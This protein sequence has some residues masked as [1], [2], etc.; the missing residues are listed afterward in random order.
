MI[1]MVDYTKVTK[2]GYEVKRIYQ[3][4]Q[5]ANF[6]PFLIAVICR[7][8]KYYPYMWAWDY[9]PRNGTWGQGNY[10][11]ESLTDAVKSLYEAYPKAKLLSHPNRLVWLKS[12][13]M[14]RDGFG[15]YELDSKD[16]MNVSNRLLFKDAY[17]IAKSRR[18]TLRFEAHSNSVVFGN[19]WWDIKHN[20]CVLFMGEFAYRVYADGHLERIPE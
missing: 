20:M 6:N 14:K 1:Q 9:D 16:I 7:P 19:L 17:R 15:W 5:N 2:E 18:D 13:Y 11:F 8:I 12:N 4:K 3:V 10:D